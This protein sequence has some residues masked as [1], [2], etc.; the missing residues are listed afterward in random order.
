MSW[1]EGSGGMVVKSARGRFDA[2]LCP[3]ARLLSLV[4]ASGH[5]LNAFGH[6]LDGVLDSFNSRGNDSS[7]LSLL[8][9]GSRSC[10]LLSLKA[11]DILL[12]LGNV[13]ELQIR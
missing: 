3:R 12:C 1:E 4:L 5:S 7:I 9:V 6:L 8:A 11:L 2:E 13:L 10:S